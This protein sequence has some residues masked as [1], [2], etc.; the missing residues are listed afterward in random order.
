MVD[1]DHEERARSKFHEALRRELP[2]TMPV[3]SLSHV[4][5]RNVGHCA[6]R[7]TARLAAMALRGV[8]T[9][10]AALRVAAAAEAWV[11]GG[12]RGGG[13]GRRI[14]AF[15]AHR[16]GYRPANIGAAPTRTTPRTLACSPS[17]WSGDTARAVEP[18]RAVVPC[19]PSGTVTPT[20]PRR[21]EPQRD[22]AILPRADGGAASRRLPIDDF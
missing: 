5:E 12:S 4:P 19:R 21:R 9:V 22:A 15:R 10:L 14:T 16:P 2:T 3:V 1:E 7:R 17:T 11:G 18:C 20:T 8:T 13:S 6:E